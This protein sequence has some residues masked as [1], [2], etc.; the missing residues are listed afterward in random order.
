MAIKIGDAILT[1]KGDTKQLN[2][3]FRDV[4]GGLDKMGAKYKQMASSIQGFGDKMFNVSK[5]IVA[6]IA[7]TTAGIAGFL[8]V[9]LK[10]AA[11]EQKVLA[12]LDAVLKSTGGA[13]GLTREEILKMNDSLV[14]M[15]AVGN[16]AIL[17]AQNLM[18]T[19]TSVGKDVFPDA[20]KAAMDLSQA[21][22][23]DLQG[24]VIQLGKALQDPIK[25]VSALS[26]VG[27]SFTEEQKNTIKALVESNRLF[28]A[29]RIILGEL[30]KQVG[31]SAQAYAQSFAGMAAR[32]QRTVG[33]TIKYVGVGLMDLLTPYVRQ[34]DAILMG[35]HDRVLSMLNSGQMQ[36]ML[37]AYLG[38]L[39]DWAMRVI[40]Q[41]ID[42]VMNNAKQAADFVY[43]FYEGLVIGAQAAWERVSWVFDALGI[44]MQGFGQDAQATGQAV[45]EMIS[46]FIE[47][48]IYSKGFGSAVGA[49]ATVVT[50]FTSTLSALVGVLGLLAGGKV[51]AGGA[52]AAG[53]A[54]ALGTAAAGVTALGAAF[55]AA[56]GVG[57]IALFTAGIWKVKESL[58]G[59]NAS[60]EKV[61]EGL[62]KYIRSL[63]A[64]GVEIDRDLMK[65]MDYAEKMSY[66]QQQKA[67]AQLEYEGVYTESQGYVRQAT[68]QTGDVMHR[69]WLGVIKL[70]ERVIDVAIRVGRHMPVIGPLIR[71]GDLIRGHA[72]GGHTR[73]ALVEAGERGPEMARLPGG[74]HTLL[75]HGIYSLPIGTYIHTAAQ[76]AAKFAAGGVVGK[77]QGNTVA[78]AQLQG[79]FM[80][81]FEK[82]GRMGKIK[83]R[84]LADAMRLLMIGISPD[85]LTGFS[86]GAGGKLLGAT[87]LL[88]GGMGTL[89]LS[90]MK[91]GGNLFGTTAQ[92]AFSVGVSG[93]PGYA[94]GGVVH[95]GAT[96]MTITI[97]TPNITVRDDADIDRVARRLGERV[98][99]FV[100]GYAT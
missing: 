13:A 22:G 66:L 41:A 98:K 96:G 73:T 88:R 1:F 82:A 44:S 75:P 40:P 83:S 84:D 17:E 11:D 93:I 62:E 49:S 97:N 60:Q 29:Q 79:R 25:G 68:E 70:F 95:G 37:D 12:Q 80:S 23:Q 58:D 65:E 92:G 50:A 16:E 38:P 34:L 27:V 85:S 91:G 90:S 74:Q 14:A 15:S 99:P 61:D 28:D 94:R 46:K 63:Q 45:G 7:G 48:S 5:K 52:A 24:S 32:I 42:F 55:L 81:M 6:G 26:R 4:S 33:D 51:A 77:T 57:G 76:T 8:G 21:F 2:A 86:V 89:S 18:L 43:G 87:G 47:F 78:L 59:L 100:M 53:G 69:V 3:A 19:F 10:A 31:G 30:E 20:I 56:V 72:R 39:L 71:G 36:S 9:A 67:R 35:V 64:K 54:G